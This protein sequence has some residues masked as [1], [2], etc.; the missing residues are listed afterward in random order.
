MSGIRVTFDRALQLLRAVQAK[1]EDLA[2]LLE[3]QRLLCRTIVRAEERIRTIKSA[4][5]SANAALH[6][7]R[8]SKEVAQSLRARIDQLSVRIEM[9]RD[10]IFISR[11][12]GDG[13]AFSYLDKHAIKQA[14]YKTDSVQKKEDAGFLS[15]KDGLG[16]EIALL[17]D[18]IG[19]GVPALLTDLTLSIR[20]GD[21]CLLGAN[22]PVL[23]EVKAGKRIGSR[24]RKQ[25]SAIETLHN[26]F[27]TDAAKG[28]RGFE[29]V[30]RAEHPSPEVTHVAELNRCIREAHT[31]G[32]SV[33]NPEEG[34]Y[35]AAIFDEE[36]EI[37]FLFAQMKLSRPMV[38]M[39]NAE[40]SNRLWA[41]YTPFVLTIEGEDNLFGF[42][43]GRVVLMVV[44]DIPVLCAAVDRAGYTVSWT[45]HADYPL[46]VTNNDTGAVGGL[47][48]H[49]IDRTGF[50]FVS[51]KWIADT[52]NSSVDRHAPPST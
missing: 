31:K 2:S 29:E 30:R 5:Q 17:E 50:E 51:L 4:Q 32:A 36:T 47:S 16:S 35:Y 23:I 45:D 48:Q 18:A 24:G 3:L 44:L 40:K 37:E 42:I 10:I 52:Y 12:F 20:Y 14:F 6:T 43:R 27:E 8:P 19:K 25:E 41:P 11:C 13:I 1:P 21:V 46:K 38:R 15:G 22:D 33:V 49:F 28:L 9:Y 7:S 39:L 26:F 34:L